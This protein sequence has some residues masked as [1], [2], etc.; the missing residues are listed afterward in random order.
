MCVWYPRFYA[1]FDTPAPASG[2]RRSVSNTML[3]KDSFGDLNW[4]CIYV[5]VPSL[6][7]RMVAAI[8]INIFV[9]RIFNWTTS[10][11]TNMLHYLFDI[12]YLNPNRKLFEEKIHRARGAHPRDNFHKI[13]EKLNNFCLMSCELKPRS[14]VTL[15]HSSRGLVF[16]V[17]LN[18]S[19]SH[20]MNQLYTVWGIETWSQ[21]QTTEVMLVHELHYQAV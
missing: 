6:Y 20:F 12:K 17:L 16:R 13:C 3:P 21:Q 4:F 19:L 7:T 9:T 11:A 8:K 5:F 1:N 18:A 2:W 15:R 14:P 10:S